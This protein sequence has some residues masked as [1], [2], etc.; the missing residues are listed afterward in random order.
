MTGI[1]DKSFG[2]WLR[3][4]IE[5]DVSKNWTLGR[6]RVR[7]EQRSKSNA[8]G[9]F[10]GGWNWQVG[11]QWSGSTTIINLLVSSLRIDKSPACDACGEWAHRN[12]FKRTDSGWG[13][14]H[15][16]CWEDRT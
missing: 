5:Y 7:Y 8:M 1:R 4:V 16:E 13:H 11:A 14:Y 6:Y 10:G 12:L 3:G 9:R 15:E 2:N